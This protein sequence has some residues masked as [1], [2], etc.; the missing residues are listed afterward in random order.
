MKAMSLLAAATLLS[1]CCSHGLSPGQSSTARFHGLFIRS[2]YS[3]QAYR[4]SQYGFDAAVVLSREDVSLLRT[5]VQKRTKDPILCMLQR[6]DG[7]T[8]VVTGVWGETE[9]QRLG[10]KT[11]NGAMYDFRRKDG[12]WTLLKW[13]FWN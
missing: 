11:G 4:R 8:R 2:E 9:T 6:D 12:A 1:G 3:V 7:S 10:A 13:G 5:M